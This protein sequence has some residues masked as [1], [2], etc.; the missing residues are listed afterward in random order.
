MFREKTDLEKL[1]TSAGEAERLRYA[2]FVI[3]GLDDAEEMKR[4]AIK[5]MRGELHGHE[6]PPEKR[7]DDRLQWWT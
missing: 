2:L 1:E 7:E 5:A 4:V 3:S 6:M